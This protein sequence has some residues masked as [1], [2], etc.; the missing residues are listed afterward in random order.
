M[1]LA[2]PAQRRSLFKASMTHT[3]QTFKRFGK[4]EICLKNF[5]DVAELF[6]RTTQT[7][8]RW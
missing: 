2:A 8:E 1:C 6:P 3:A 5:Q 4:R 7:S